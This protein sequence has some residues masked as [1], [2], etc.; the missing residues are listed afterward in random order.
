MKSESVNPE[1]YKSK[2][3]LFIQL[4]RFESFRPIYFSLFMQSFID[5][6][7]GFILFFSSFISSIFLFSSTSSFCNW[8]YSETI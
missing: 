3:S 1:F 6:S 4:V 5:S 7:F 2:Q 8:C